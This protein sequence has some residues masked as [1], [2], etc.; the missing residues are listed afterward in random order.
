[1]EN[2]VLEKSYNEII[3]YIG[4]YENNVSKIN[5]KEVIGKATLI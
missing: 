1:M 5:A 2:T 3:S 4:K